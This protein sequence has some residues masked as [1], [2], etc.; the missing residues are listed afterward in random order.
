M[1]SQ[2]LEVLL[3]L[4][5]ARQNIDYL[6]IDARILVGGFSWFFAPKISTLYLILSFS[7]VSLENSNFV[8]E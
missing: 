3:L 1:P 2:R 5:S 6:N 7:I 8:A 4:T